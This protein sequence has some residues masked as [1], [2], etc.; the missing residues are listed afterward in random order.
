VP[1]KK[2]DAVMISCYQLTQTERYNI[3]ALLRVRRSR[4]EVASELGRM[5]VTWRSLALRGFMR[6]I[7]EYYASCSSTSK[8]V[9]D[10]LIRWFFVIELLLH[11]LNWCIW[12]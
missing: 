7:I 12:S 9:I 11:T 6:N 8:K 1:T 3:T 2:E 10:I 5:A 4:S